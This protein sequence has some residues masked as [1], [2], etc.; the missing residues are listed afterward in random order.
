VH[1]IGV[2]DSR[3]RGGGD[4]R[5][6]RDARIRAVVADGAEARTLDDFAHLHGVDR[7]VSLPY[8]AVTTTAVRVIGTRGPRPRSIG[9]SASAPAS[10]PARAE[11]RQRGEVSGAVW[12]RIDGRPGVLWHV[13]AG[14]TKG[15]AL[16]P[17]EYER[18][19]VGLF[20]RALL[21]G[22]PAGPRP[23]SELASRGP[24][25]PRPRP[26]PAAPTGGRSRVASA[27]LPERRDRGGS[28]RRLRR[29]P[30]GCRRKQVANAHLLG[31]QP[32][33]ALRLARHVRVAD[34]RPAW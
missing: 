13:D 21:G 1:R 32:A 27:R 16:H 29:L 8:W 5:R 34:F 12:A 2:L 19:V 22:R 14:H 30:L 18:R 9:S 24:G 15:L 3:R 11:Q 25:P 10:A 4:H 23:L 6:G 31:Q 7:L 26:F 17:R 20:D 28:A 33:K